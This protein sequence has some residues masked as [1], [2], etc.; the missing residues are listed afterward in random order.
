MERFAQR[1]SAKRAEWQ[2]RVSH[3][4]E[5]GQRAVVWGGGAKA[6][7]FF[8]LLEIGGQ[9]EYVVDINPGKQGSYLAGSGLPIV[10]PAFLKRYRPDVV[11]VMNPLYKGEIDQQLADLGISAETVTVLPLL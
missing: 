1:F 4:K 8:S 6:V 9:I 3:L 5:A 7:S 2:R 10:A 11:I